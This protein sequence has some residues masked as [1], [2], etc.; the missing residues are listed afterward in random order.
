M[1]GTYALSAGYYDAYY[2][3]AQ[4]VRTLVIRRLRGPTR[5]ST[6][7]FRRLLLGLRSRSG[8]R[9]RTRSRCTCTTCA[10]SRPTWRATRPDV[11]FGTGDDGLPVGVQVL[12]P[13]LGETLMFQVAAALEAARPPAGVTRG[14]GRMTR[15]EART[16]RGRPSSVSRCTA[17]S[18]PRR[19]SS[20]A[21]GTPS[22]KSRTPTSARSASDFPG[23]LPVLNR[24]AV[25]LAM[26]IGTALHC[27]IAAFDL[28]PE[29]LLLSG[30][31]EGLPDQPVRRADQ[32][33]RLP[34]SA[35]RHAGRDRAGAHRGGHRQDDP[36]R[37]RRPHPRGRPLP[38]GLQ[39]GRRAPRRDRRRAPTS[40]SPARPGPT[41]TSCGRSWSRPG[42]PTA[43]GGGSLRV[44]A[45]VSVRPVGSTEYGTRC[46][47]KNLNS[48]RSLGR[49]IDYEVARQIALSRP[50]SGSPQETRHWDEGDGRT[51][52]MRSK[53]EANDYRYFPE[54]DLVPR[55]AGR[56]LL[57]AAAEGV[58][59]MPAERRRDSRS[60]VAATRSGCARDASTDQVVTVVDLGLDELVTGAVGSRRRRAARPRAGRERGGRETGAARLARPGRVCRRSSRMEAAGRS[61]P[62]SRKEVLAELM[63]AGGDPARSPRGSASSDGQRAL[64]AVVDEVIASNPEEWERYCA[65]EEKWRSSSSARYQGRR[66]RARPNGKVASADRRSPALPRKRAAGAA[67]YRL[68]RM[69]EKIRVRSRLEAR[70]V[71]HRGL[72]S[73]RPSRRCSGRRD[74]RRRLRQASGRRR[75]DL[76]RGHA[77]QP[78]ARPAGQAGEGRRARAGGFPFEFVTI[79]VSDGISMGHEGMHASLVSREVI[80]DSVEAVMHAERFDAFVGLAG[81]DKSLPGML[82]AAGR[83]DLPMVFVYGGTIL[84]GRL[85]ERAGHRLGVRGGRRALGRARSTTRSWLRSSATPARRKAPAPACSPPTPWHRSPKLSAWRSRR[86]LGR[87][88]VD[89][90]RDDIAYASGQAVV[91]LLET[92]HPPA[93][94]HDEGG[95]RERHRRRHGSWRLDQRR[96]HLL[97]IANEA[98]VE[99]QLDDFARIGRKVPHLADM[100]PHGR[101]HMTDLDRIGGVPVVLQRAARGGPAQRRL[102]DGH[103]KDDGREPRRP[104]PAGP[105]RLGRPPLR[106][107]DP[108]RRWD[109]HPAWI[110]RSRG[111]RGQVA[112]I[113]GDSLRRSGPRL[114]RRGC[115]DG[116]H[117]RRSDPPGRSWSSA[118]RDRRAV[119]GCARCS[120]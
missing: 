119:R 25:E 15:R 47:V 23:S 113:D 115:R 60:S 35:R 93:A 81:C 27:R 52:S 36:C 17:S 106:G 99:L 73:G 6:C 61:R 14:T 58:G 22:A 48:L 94:D 83:L 76:E 41:S 40:R 120:P 71:S 108:L 65:G 109:R 88:A 45:N 51:H 75:L 31:A 59:P 118:T 114:R 111:R 32:R 100:K 20:A 8:R 84:P 82:M 9:R 104:R 70:S 62:R 110:A 11:P 91:G 13:A 30:H 92:G 97:A 55:R 19:S 10:R 85:G 98:R 16:R 86:R 66:R 18:R 29:E 54:P 26:R 39:P 116:R 64:E 77:L 57:A 37:R 49:A 102:P 33:R 90:R 72:P 38:R 79:S 53:E 69:A 87:P 89:R 3:Q 63:D 112:G 28:P 44:D 2:G 12:A 46:E 117:L 80:A 42:S 50:A 34:R 107:A 4:R 105:R 67:R 103:G 43:D 21:A 95:L 101:Y 24:R 78:A 5:L 56:Q 96:L 74:D 7:C 1:L 68:S